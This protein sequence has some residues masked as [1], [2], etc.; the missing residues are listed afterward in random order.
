MNLNEYLG[1]YLTKSAASGPGYT[2]ALIFISLPF[3]ITPFWIA[4]SSATGASVI[5]FSF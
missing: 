4:Y 1:D 5:V 3:Q 2:D